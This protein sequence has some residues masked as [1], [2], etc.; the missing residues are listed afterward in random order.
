MLLLLPQPTNPIEAKSANSPNINNQLR[1]RLGRASSATNARAVPPA[2]G[3][4]NPFISFAAL[5]IAVV[6]T[7]SVDVCAVAPVIATDVGFN[8]HPGMS[9]T[10]VMDV[11][12]LQL[13]FTVPVN[14]FV[15]ATLI[16]AVLP[17][18]APGTTDNDVLPP[19]PD[20]KLG[21]AV[22]V[23]EMLVV[24]VREPEVPVTVT[25]AGPPT[26]AVLAA[27]R[28]STCV[29]AAVPAAK[30]AVT[31]VGNPDA[32]SVTVPAN[33][34]KLDTEIVIVPLPF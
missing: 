23:R 30:P 11:V 3:P 17:V 27:V 8:P 13:R 16:V 32:A 4:K 33:P 1:R 2:S 14:P 34:P 25:V 12:T 7:V 10:P 21:S 20:V 26:T 6:V 22:M 9:L 5:D 18:V 24:A 15:P 28:V 19:V 31:P 29:P